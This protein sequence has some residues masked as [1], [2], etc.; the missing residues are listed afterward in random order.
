MGNTI[1]NHSQFRSKEM[2]NEP[3]RMANLDYNHFRRC[4]CAWRMVLPAKLIAISI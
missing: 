4:D 1:T 2:T 3:D